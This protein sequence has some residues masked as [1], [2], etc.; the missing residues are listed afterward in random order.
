MSS[1]PHFPLAPA[2]LWLQ[3]TELWTE[4][5]VLQHEVAVSCN[6]VG[7]MSA[8]ALRILL[9]TGK[10]AGCWLWGAGYGVLPSGH[11]WELRSASPSSCRILIP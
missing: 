9:C 4:M 8:A 3:H 11:C 6:C 5:E 7:S 2:L 1:E 10:H